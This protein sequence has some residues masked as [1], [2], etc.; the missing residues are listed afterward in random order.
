MEGRIPFEAFS[1]AN[2]V[3]QVEASATVCP[4]ICPLPSGERAREKGHMGGERLRALILGVFL[5]VCHSFAPNVLAQPEEL[6]TP[7]AIPGAAQIVPDADRIQERIE[8]LEKAG[9]NGAARELEWLRQ[10][11]KFL[12]R[13]TESTSKRPKSSKPSLRPR[14][15]REASRRPSARRWT[16]PVSTRI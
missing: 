8:Q 7:P 10:A 12:E 13:A 15:S 2:R 14:S 6:P 3:I 9:A 1:S 16:S 11:Q 4:P 5:I